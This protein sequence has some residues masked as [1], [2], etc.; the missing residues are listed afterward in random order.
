LIAI[1]NVVFPIF[2]II[3]IGYMA[4]AK[5][6]VPKAGVKTLANFVF[7]IALPALLF[8]ST[9]TA[10]LESLLNWEFISINLGGILVNFFVA[11][12]ISKVIFKRSILSSSLYGMNASYGNTGYMGIPLLI[13]AFG[14][15]AALPAAIATLIHNLPI[16]TVVLIIGETIF[17]RDYKEKQS[18]WH[19]IFMTLK[20][21]L[22]NPITISVLAGIL[23]A[24]SGISLPPAIS[25]LA[26]LL[27]NASG[28]TALF[29]IGLGF[30]GQFSLMK[31][32]GFNKAEIGLIVGLKL[33]FQPFITYILM[34]Y[35]FDVEALW[36]ITSVIMSALPVGAG[37]Y[38]FAQ[39]YEK[40]MNQ[41]LSAI[42][43]SN[44]FS[45][46]SL[47]LL[48]IYISHYFVY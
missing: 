21:V 25:T 17:V 32:T 2:A 44:L 42:L 5:N 30:V 47:S 19:T 26:E 16:I 29:A 28:S 40:M 18:L 31:S 37:V 34:M 36:A 9:A 35:V 13:A 39:K 43:F 12:I 15:E 1:I 10:P 24:L 8:Q 27:A 46:I 3:L 45:V 22:K 7:Y 20:P 4:G 38:V 14:H 48:L 33:L 11:V 6:I 41:T 23:V